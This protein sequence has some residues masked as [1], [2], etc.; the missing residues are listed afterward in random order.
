M[1]RVKPGNTSK[2]IPTSPEEIASLI[3]MAPERV[4]D[5]ECPYDPNDPT[6]VEEFWK[7]ATV[8]RP[9]GSTQTSAS[10]EVREWTG[11]ARLRSRSTPR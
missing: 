7:N 10:P 4:H 5:P 8:G 3:G 9:G 11:R 6:A 2:P 1:A